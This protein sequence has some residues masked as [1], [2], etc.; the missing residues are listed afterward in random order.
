LLDES[1][2]CLCADP[3]KHPTAGDIFTADELA[4]AL[5]KTYSSVLEV[6]FLRKGRGQGP[7]QNQWYKAEALAD[8]DVLIALLDDYDVTLAIS[9]ADRQSSS[10]EYNKMEY[11]GIKPG[12]VTIAWMRNWFERWLTRPWLGNFDLLLTSSDLATAFFADISAKVGFPTACSQACP[13][14]SDQARSSHALPLQ[15]QTGYRFALPV[16]TMRLATN[17]DSFHPGPATDKY[18]ADYTF[19]GSYYGVKRRVMEFDPGA[20][21]L[22]NFKGVIV[23]KGWQQANVSD[24]WK[25]CAIGGVPYSDIPSVSDFVNC[26]SRI[27]SHGCASSIT[28]FTDPHC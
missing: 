6:R 10:N 9:A 5:L 24:A 25:R 28:R 14:V 17:P 4:T 23:G 27:I 12:L 16:L 1:F 21:Q 22:S 26:V 20:P 8:V 18:K 3:A 19:T 13:M 7:G 11:R 2:L 15:S